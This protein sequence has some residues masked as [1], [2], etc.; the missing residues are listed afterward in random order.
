M[1]AATPTMSF[2]A[3]EQPPA[4]AADATGATAARSRADEEARRLAAAVARGDEAAFRRLYDAYQARLF[5]F[6]LVLGRG[7]EWLA[8]E[9]VQSVFLTTAAKL[10]SVAGEEHLWNWLA[11]VARQHLAKHW[12]QQ[13]RESAMVSMADLPNTA[14]TGQSE[15]RLEESLDAALLELDAEDRQLIERF[16]LDG[17]SQKEVAG[18]L[19]LTP[20]AVSSRLER[21][22][23]R[24]RALVAKRLAHET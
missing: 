20:K 10:R 24:L 4:P 14:E 1:T 12:R 3:R 11:R 8:H 22:R 2:L 15:A 17:R 6:A 19:N 13:G 18:E 5:R 9:T 23:A 21:A 7:D 16:Y